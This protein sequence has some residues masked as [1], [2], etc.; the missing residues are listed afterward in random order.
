MDSMYISERTYATHCE[1]NKPDDH[2]VQKLSKA[3]ILSYVRK[4][5]ETSLQWKL[6]LDRNLFSYVNVDS[7]KGRHLSSYVMLQFI[8]PQAVFM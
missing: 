4:V 5:W 8:A 3:P 7:I 1:Y 6:G 2:T